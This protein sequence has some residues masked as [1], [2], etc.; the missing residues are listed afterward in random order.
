VTRGGEIPRQIQDE[1]ARQQD[2]DQQECE[3]YT[4]LGIVVV[5]VHRQGS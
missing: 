3:E 1:Q 4:R 2:P 5:L